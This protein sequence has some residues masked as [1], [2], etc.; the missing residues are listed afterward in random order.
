MEELEEDLGMSVQ[1]SEG[2]EL[3]QKGPITGMSFTNSQ[4]QFFNNA[5]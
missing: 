3:V 4:L 2:V 5:N 1:E